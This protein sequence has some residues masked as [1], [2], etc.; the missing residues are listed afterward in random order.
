MDQMRASRTYSFNAAN[1][2]PGRDPYSGQG[3][4]SASGGN[5]ELRPWIADVADISIEKYFDGSRA[6]VSLAAFYRNLETFIY[7]ANIPFDFTGFPTNGVVPVTNEGLSYSP[8]NGEGGAMWGVEFAASIPFDMFTE[9]LDG[10]GAYFSVS[11]NDSEIKQTPTSQ[12][13]AIPGLSETIANLT[14]Y[15]EKYGFQARLNGRYRSEFLGELSGF[16]NGRTLR[17]VGDETILDGQI[18]YEFQSGP[19]EGLSILASVNNITDEPFSTYN[20]GDE[21]QLINYQSYG[22]TFSVGLNY[23]F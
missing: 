4:W 9:T 11:Q 15:Y 22:R 13:T 6:Y 5:P 17:Q 12:P 19:A 1:N 21:R 3:P 7:D 20:N 23:R 8:E 10:F 18:G 16:A 14:I 2:V